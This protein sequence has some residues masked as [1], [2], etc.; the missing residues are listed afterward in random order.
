MAKPTLRL[1]REVH[2]YR[3]GKVD[4]LAQRTSG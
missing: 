2:L 1:A 4:R 3:I